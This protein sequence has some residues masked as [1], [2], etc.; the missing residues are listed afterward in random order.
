MSFAGNKIWPN[1]LPTSSSILQHLIISTHWLCKWD[2]TGVENPSAKKM[3]EI[4]WGSS[5]LYWEILKWNAIS[6]I[7]GEI[8]NI[9]IILLTLSL[10]KRP[11]QTGSFNINLLCLTPDNFTRQGRASGWERVNWAYSICPSLF[12]KGYK[13]TF[14]QEIS[15]FLFASSQTSH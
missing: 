11:A 9:I 4:S 12:L 14:F 7:L 2:K 13:M 8:L 10:L 6:C 15:N 5:R 1:M 3:Q